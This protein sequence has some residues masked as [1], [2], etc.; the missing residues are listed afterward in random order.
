M[1]NKYEMVS[2]RNHIVQRLEH[3][4]SETLWE[5]DGLEREIDGMA[6][7][8]TKR[9]TRLDHNLPE[10]TSAI[11]LAQECRIP[12]ILP[13]AFYHISLLHPNAQWCDDPLDDPTSANSYRFPS[14]TADR[15]KLTVPDLLCLIRGREN[16]ATASFH[17]PDV[18]VPCTDHWS[19]FCSLSS[20][21]WIWEQIRSDC[22]SSKDVLATLGVYIESP[23]TDFTDGMC[24]V[25]VSPMRKTLRDLRQK[26]WNNLS[27]IFELDCLDGYVFPFASL[28]W[29]SPTVCS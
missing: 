5:W 16:L 8:W 14:R 21:K 26:I 9:D 27:A 4:W 23:D 15:H 13:P 2:L 19:D 12:S 20:H 17:L 28:D 7:S 22:A 3:D 29:H 11:R 25:C 1:A 10:P 18:P 24:S 6:G